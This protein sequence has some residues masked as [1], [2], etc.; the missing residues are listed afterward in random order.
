MKYKIINVLK[1]VAVLIL[2]MVMTF[3]ITTAL[4]SGFGKHTSMVQPEIEIGGMQTENTTSI[5][6]GDTINLSPYITNTCSAEIYV[7]VSI[8]QELLQDPKF[9]DT[10]AAEPYMVSDTNSAPVCY[11]SH[12]YGRS[13]AGSPVMGCPSAEGFPAGRSFPRLYPVPWS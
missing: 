13:S 1:S 11:L 6:P 2:S 3:G 8:L 7:S 4:T 5:A 10:P 12:G 9:K